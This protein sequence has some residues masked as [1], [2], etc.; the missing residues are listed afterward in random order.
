MQDGRG[1][2]GWQLREA[3]AGRAGQGGAERHGRVWL[4]SG[5]GPPALLLQVVRYALGQKYGA[6]RDF[7]NP[8]DYHKQPSMLRMVDY[9]ARNRWAECGACGRRG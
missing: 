4:P 2:G 6:H 9:G 8:N 7:F 5:L 1:A 3:R